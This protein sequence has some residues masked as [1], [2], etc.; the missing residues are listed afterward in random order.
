MNACR[1]G[2]AWGNSS[3]QK[4]VLQGIYWTAGRPKTV[5]LPDRTGDKG[6]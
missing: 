5:V 4:L 2:K 3:F 6:E 1:L